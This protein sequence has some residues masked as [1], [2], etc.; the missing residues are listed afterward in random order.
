MRI[1]KRFQNKKEKSERQNLNAHKK[2]Q[3]VYGKQETDTEEAEREKPTMP[4]WI[5]GKF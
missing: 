1:F 5:I 4:E 2:L 3:K